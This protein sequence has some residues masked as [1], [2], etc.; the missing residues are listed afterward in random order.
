MARPIS[1]AS[2]SRI[3]LVEGQ[4]DEYVVSRL[5]ERHKSALPFSILN[6]KTISRLLPA[7]SIEIKAS[8]RQAVGIL[9]DADDD[10]AARWDAVRGQLS[11]AGISPPPSPD[12]AGTIIDG[13]PR[14]GIWLMPDNESLGEFENFVVRMIPGGDQVWPLSQRYI[15]EIP[16]AQRKF[17]AKKKL[18]AQLYAWLAAREDPRQMGLAIRAR[19]L[20]VD[21]E[22]SNTFVAWLTKLFG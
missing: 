17:S 9:V 8:D 16:E 7:I 18:R 21:G 3:L 1:S 19:D 6:K 14:I 5:L 11:K 2:D 22:L 12:S 20:E 13:T 4:D 10:I 15:E